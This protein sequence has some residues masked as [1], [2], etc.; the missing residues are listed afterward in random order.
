MRKLFLAFA[1]SQALAGAAFAQSSVTVFG[2]LDAGVRH[3]DNANAG[4]LTTE[5]TNGLNSN[6]L[7]FRGVEEIAPGLKAAFWLEHGFFADTGTANP[8][9]WNRGSW[10]SLQSSTFGEVRLGRDYTPLFRGY[11]NYDPF[12]VNGLGSI[13][14]ILGV[15]GSN[16][17]S[18]TTVDNAVI[19]FLPT[20][21]YGLYGS[22][23]AAAG[24]G[25]TTVNTAA[26]SINS[27]N[28]MYGGTLGYQSGPLNV[29]A[30]YTQTTIEVGIPGKLKQGQVGAWYDFGVAKVM[31]QYIQSE[32]INREQ[33]LIQVGALVP[34]GAGTIR[35]S[36]TDGNMKGSSPVIGFRSQDDTSMFALG[37]IHNL[38]KRTALY[39]TAAITKN[40]GGASLTVPGGP[41]G[42]SGGQDS[43]G[44]EA[45]IRHIF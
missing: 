38:S 37:Y 20:N 36:Y 32:Y 19:Y 24:E 21:F 13:T 4:K 41:A 14:N 25:V 7:G 18:L 39:T 31:A 34:I 29:Q 44:I 5:S 28:K 35:V 42:M 23:L 30:A 1:I 10:V 2:V 22:V 33:G 27:N 12:N 9:F 45:G 6:R 11:V 40:K 17:P 16:S 43:K 26:S 8:K 3:V 15:L